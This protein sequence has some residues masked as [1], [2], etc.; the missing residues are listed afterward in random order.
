MAFFVAFYSYKGGV[1]RSL[2]LANTGY[3]L[4]AHGK[5]VVLVDMDLEAPGLQD[6]PEFALKGSG[7]KKGFLDYAASYR[8]TGR[9]PAIKSY[10]HACRESPGTGKLWLMPAGNFGASYQEQLGDLAWRRLHPEHG[11]EPFVEGF[12]QALVKEFQPHYVLIDART[13]LSDIGGLSTHRLA[14]MVVLVFNLTRSS[15]EGSVRTYRSFTSSES[16]VRAVQLVASPV[17]PLLPG[18]DSI[19]KS[20]LDQACELMS[21]GTAY[22]RTLIRLDYDPS[23]VLAEELAV[24]HSDELP[25]ANRYEALRESIQRANPVEVFPVVEQAK[26]LR[27][28]GQLE[29][30]LTLLRSF[31]KAHPQDS[32]GHLELGNLFFEAERAEEAAEAFQKAVDLAPDLPLPHRR[33]GEALAAIG[34]AQAIEALEKAES[35]GERSRELYTALAQAYAFQGDTVQETEARRKAIMALLGDE[36]ERPAAPVQSLDTLR[37]EFVEV[38]GRRLPFAG[39]QPEVFWDDLMGAF[40]LSPREKRRVVRSLLSG[41]VRA[42]EIAGLTRL[43]EEDKSRAVEKL[44]PRAT[45]LR[46]RIAQTFVDPRD[47]HALL[48]LRRDDS[49]DSALLCHIA[50][51]PGSLDR[52]IELLEEAVQKDPENPVAWDYLGTYL[53]LRGQ[54]E[55]GDHKRKTLQKA[56]ESLSQS[57]R[58]APERYG[59]LNNW[60]NAL[61]GLAQLAEDDEKRRLLQEAIPKFQEAVRHKQPPHEAF[62]NWGNALAN[63]AE[64]AEGDEKQRLFQEALLKFKEAARLQL[65]KYEALNNWGLT[66]VALAHLAENNERQRLFQEAALRYQEAVRHKPDFHEALNNWGIALVELASLAEGDEKRRLLIDA[67]LKFQEALR[68]KPDFHKALNNWGNA[69]ADLV[70]LAE[71]D[72]K[73]RLL[74]EAALRYQEA[75]QY[76]PDSPEILY[77]WGITLNSLARLAEG[78]EKQRFLEEASLKYQEAIRQKP[79][80]NEAFGG[81]GDAIADLAQLA[82]GDK[83]RWLLKEAS[84]KYQEALQHKPDDHE[85]LNRWVNVLLLLSYLTEGD[86]MRSIA[87]E[88]ANKAR[89]AN[90]IQPGVGDYNLAC[91]LSRLEQFDEAAELLI[92][93]LQRRPEVRQHALQ[94][95]D[96]QPLWLAKP[97]LHERISKE[98][99]PQ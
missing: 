74:E 30:G 4:A 22:G 27:S 35:L 36:R 40:S 23:M 49:V 9:C 25:A 17:P 78:N 28:A 12:R 39:F 99:S 81:W 45:E 66:L 44:G 76:K 54:E 20:R 13:G 24:R 29:E 37:G 89:E 47:A 85:A 75:V 63:L 73:R 64:L 91:A 59:A 52:K 51:L 72:E 84:I 96:L 60:G 94:D 90:K 16:R 3:A 8:R 98:L 33:L 77:N 82:Q 7:P 11:T 95:R 62:Q 19:A 43:L 87:L 61:E 38:L 50:I 31:V 88:A 97:E 53:L 67:R 83:K 68:H 15:L 2:A 42:S 69:L 70:S 14:D 10:V 18:I 65:D 5:R 58:L 55:Q 34:Q 79:D 71:S 1:G 6:I 46:Q 48:G 32:Q 80:F 57:I 21:L 41:S 92:A 86:E 93:D 56:E 26:E